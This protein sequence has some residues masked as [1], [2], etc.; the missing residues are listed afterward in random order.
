MI[1]T[2]IYKITSPSGK[3]YIGQSVDIKRR[4]RAYSAAHI[5]RQPKL[6]NSFIKHGKKN[7][8]FDVVHELPKDIDQNVLNTYEQ[9]YMDT[10]REAGFIL[11]NIKEAGSIGAMSS[12][13]KLK[14]SNSNKGRKRSKETCEKIRAAKTGFK[15]S[16]ES[17]SKMSTSHM[18]QSFK[19]P[20]LSSSRKQKLSILHKGISLEDKFGKLKADE[21]KKK[22]S[23]NSR[24]RK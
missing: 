20:P 17:K 2:G 23:A 6:F 9:F 15:F 10:Y 24:W 16:E 21:I 14:I 7:H 1:I 12:E 11:L 8:N 18:G 19:K 5:K 13:T 3:I 22:I 4:F